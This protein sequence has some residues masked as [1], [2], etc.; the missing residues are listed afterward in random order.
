MIDRTQE[1]GGGRS[2]ARACPVH[3][4]TLTSLF[5]SVSRPRH[6]IFVE[7]RLNRV[8]AT[9]RVTAEVIAPVPWFPFTAPSFGRYAEF[10]STPAADVRNG[11]TI[12]YPRYWTLPKAG[13][14]WQAASMARAVLRHLRRTPTIRLP[15]LI[16][17]QYLYPDG[18]ASAL[19]AESV[20]RPYVLTAR[21]TDV[22]VLARDR[23]VQPAIMRAIAEAAIT[24]T[25]S[26]ALRESL[27]AL[28]C[29]AERIV[30][31]R[32]GVDLDLFS[33]RDRPLARRSLGVATKY[34]V[35]AVGNLVPEK[36][37]ALAIEALASVPDTTL[38]IVGDG[39]ERS[40]LECRA[41]A[42]GLED[43][44]F[45]LPSRRQQELVDVYSAAD[46]MVLPSS[47]EGWPNVILE[48]MACGTPVVASDVGGVREMMT[49]PEAGLKVSGDNP[50]DF[51]A[52]IVQLLRNP[53]ERSRVRDHARQ[54]AW[55]SI[56]EQQA[57][58][59]ERV[60]GSSDSHLSRSA[61]AASPPLGSQL[62]VRT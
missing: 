46:L 44:V 17:G 10:A 5:P 33:P 37:H 26:A 31:L 18:V 22:N 47:R 56:A 8:V 14:R 23:R 45:L 38:I 52:A 58:L 41:T 40:R 29:D 9:G 28:G 13:L 3:V 2:V 16:D 43:R 7:T 54:F 53:P 1:R 34:V 51:A 12:S 24:I 6:G 49:V 62:T 55:D 39:P 48:A 27:V 30:C 57:R 25:V 15:D 20:G 60:V 11:L 42:L 36:R 59:Y 4:L 35:A 19:V 21:G 50:A 61:A 32:N